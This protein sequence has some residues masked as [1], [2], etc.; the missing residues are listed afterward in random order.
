MAYIDLFMHVFV[1]VMCLAIVM[2]PVW[3]LARLLT[4]S[5][6]LQFSLAALAAMFCINVVLTSWY[7]SFV[8]PPADDHELVELWERFRSGDYS[9]S[10]EWETID[11]RPEY[12]SSCSGG[13]LDAR[14]RLL[15][16]RNIYGFARWVDQGATESSTFVGIWVPSI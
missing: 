11:G 7:Y 6:S 8:T 14:D 12:S 16:S 13:V 9:C 5:R 4:F 1:V 3:L 2:A 15:V 10:G